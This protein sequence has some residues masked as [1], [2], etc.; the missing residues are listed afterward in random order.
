MPST[1]CKEIPRGFYGIF[2]VAEST[3]FV[4]EALDPLTII[5]NIDESDVLTAL[6]TELE[7]LLPKKEE[8]AT[9]TNVDPFV[10]S[11]VTRDGTTLLICGP[12]DDMIGKTST[13]L[14]SFA[15]GKGLRLFAVSVGE[16]LPPGLANLYKGAGPEIRLSDLLPDVREFLLTGKTDHMAPERRPRALP[17][18]PPGKE[19]DYEEVVE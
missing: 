18:L 5:P 10:R 2:V 1:V 13:F 14:W 19:I 3:E 9:S 7:T 6:S 17:T 12:T 16:P 8:L 4:P 11:A 15:Q